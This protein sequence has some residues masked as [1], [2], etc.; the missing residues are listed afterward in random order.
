M[1]RTF[2][3]MGWY[4]NNILSFK[5]QSHAEVIDRVECP[6]TSRQQTVVPNVLRNLSRLGIVQMLHQA[7]HVVDA[8]SSGRLPLPE[9]LCYYVV[10]RD[11]PPKSSEESS[12]LKSSLRDNR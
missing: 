11:N 7:Q 4:E 12:L 5:I 10:D 9:P 1:S 3:M 2:S 6:K 8:R